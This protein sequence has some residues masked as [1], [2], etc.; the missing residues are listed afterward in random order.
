VGDLLFSAVNLAR[1]LKV[2]PESAL[3]TTNARFKRRFKKLEASAAAQH[4]PLYEMSTDEI[5]TLWNEAKQ[6][7]NF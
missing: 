3:R 1:W 2:D 7:E 6:D 5:L 4:K